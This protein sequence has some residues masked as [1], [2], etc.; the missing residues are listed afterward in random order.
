MTEQPVDYS[1]LS[2]DFML[3]AIESIGIRVDSGLLELNSY[4]NRVFQF[5]D[6]ER[7]RFV[8]KFY[9]PERWSD[10]QIKE[11]HDFS[12]ELKL[13]EID[14]VAPLLFDGS[15]LFIYQGYRFAI[16]PS[17]GGR[18][19]EVDNLDALESVGR[20]LGRV[21]QLASQRPFIHRPS[22][23]IAEFVQTPKQILQQHSFVPMHLETSFFS[24]Y[25]TLA[26]EIALQYKPDDKQLIRLHGDLHAG[27]ILW[28]D[29]VTL[30]DFDDCRQG[31]AIQDMW[32]M[33]HGERHEQLLQ[34]EVMLEGYEE[35]SSF[36]TKQ[37]ALIEP[38]RAMRMMHYM[39]WIAKRW[40]DPAF[41]RHF[42]W[43]TDELYWQQQ[44]NVLQ[45]QIDNM[46]KSPL[47]LI[48]NY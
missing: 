3:D 16:F 21:H 46:Q 34:L 27:N 18:P 10:E 25:D 15:S 26:K 5:Q 28:R 30:L 14:V 4:E 11:E 8:V 43:F 42:A 7:Q 22:L 41:S 31:P 29:K 37:L 23:S 39:G 36:D 38:L 24:A 1:L 19:I 40:N 35:F 47:S 44:V 6:E 12:L 45:E 33:L 20:N 48:P 2:P 17:A 32:M 9:R 13:A